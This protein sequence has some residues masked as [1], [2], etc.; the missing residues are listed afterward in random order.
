MARTK[1][2]V[3]TIRTTAEVK[4]LLK[5]AAER[6]RRSAASMVEVLVL[7]YAEAHGVTVPELDRRGRKGVGK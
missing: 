2:E 7:S 1:N 3:L 6:E 5:L 4:A